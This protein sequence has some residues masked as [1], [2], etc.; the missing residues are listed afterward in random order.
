M[1]EIQRFVSRIL[2]EDKKTERVRGRQ[3]RRR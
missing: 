1:W 3:E 2:K